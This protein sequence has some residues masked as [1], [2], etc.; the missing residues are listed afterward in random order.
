MFKWLNK[1]FQK[2]VQSE[3]SIEEYASLEY[4]EDFVNKLN[5][6][7]L[8]AN[9]HYGSGVYVCGNLTLELKLMGRGNLLFDCMVFDKNYDV[10]Y[11]LLK[12]SL[13]VTAYRLPVADYQ[14][15][16]AKSYLNRDWVYE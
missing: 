8:G 6:I 3:D 5:S 14:L 10:L 11:H 1:L 9:L 2:E 13:W 7:I 12:E 15:D 4:S 16:L